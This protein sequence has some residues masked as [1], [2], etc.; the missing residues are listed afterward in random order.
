MRY[1]S[2]PI[3]FGYDFTC[4]DRLSRTRRA[5]RVTH[6]WCRRRNGGRRRGVLYDTNQPIHRATIVRG[7]MLRIANG[8]RLHAAH[9]GDGPKSTC[10]VLMTYAHVGT[11]VSMPGAFASDSIVIFEPWYLAIRWRLLNLRVVFGRY[12]SPIASTC[13]TRLCGFSHIIRFSQFRKSPFRIARTTV[14]GYVPRTMIAACSKRY[15]FGWTECEVWIRP[16]QR[17][18]CEI[19]WVYFDHLTRRGAIR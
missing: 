13:T 14:I 3:R 5:S 4:S 11:P 12:G 17:A 7:S 2:Q 8:A 10:F 18:A 6:G 19:R 9:R 15:V 1:R 16:T